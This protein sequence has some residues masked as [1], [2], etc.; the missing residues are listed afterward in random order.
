LIHQRIIDILSWK[1]NRVDILIKAMKFIRLLIIQL[2]V[3]GLAV[4]FTK[5]CLAQTKAPSAK[6]K[7]DTVYLKSIKSSN[8]KI[9]LPKIEDVSIYEDLFNTYGKLKTIQ[10]KGKK[11]RFLGDIKNISRAKYVNGAL[12]RAG[13]ANTRIT[14]FKTWVPPVIS[15]KEKEEKPK[16]KKEKEVA[17]QTAIVGEQVNK[18]KTSDPF[19]ARPKANSKPSPEKN[20]IKAEDKDTKPKNVDKAVDKGTKPTKPKSPGKVEDKGTKPAKPK[21]TNKVADKDTKPTKPKSPGKVEA[22]DTKPAKPKSVDK[23]AANNQGQ[24]VL[25]LP[26]VTNPE[27][28]QYVLKDLGT[29]D[30]KKLPNEQWYYFLGFFDNEAKAKTFIPK[31]KERGFAKP[32]KIAN[33]KNAEKVALTM[34]KNLPPITKKKSEPKKKNTSSKNVD[35]TLFYRIEL[36]RVSNPEIYFKAFGDIGPGHSEIAPNG[37]GIYYIGEFETASAATTKMAK[38]KERGLNN[39]TVVKFENDKRLDPYS[40]I[41]LTIPKEEKNENVKKVEVKKRVSTNPKGSFQIRMKLVENPDV[42]KAVFKDVGKLKIGYYD[43]DSEYYYM[44]NYLFQEEAK[45]VIGQLKERGLTQFKL[46][47]VMASGNTPAIPKTKSRNVY[48]IK[49]GTLTNAEQSLIRPYG[50]VTNTKIENEEVYYLGDYPTKKV[51]NII[52]NVLKEVGFKKSMN[53]EFFSE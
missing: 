33:L 12:N 17:S 16:E 37:K 39:G 3:I 26:K 21:S 43:D 46:L 53:V 5:D 27:V 51:A 7:I 52:A 47:N 32:P 22:K 8:F 38:L 4:S 11:R 23:V 41:Y 2:I 13:I 24:F 49:L 9:R 34:Y 42:L 28:Y 44:G 50:T 30:H 35:K 31:I 14:L 6:V 40:E 1:L 18:K 19:P 45:K 29:V 10:V 36:P 20:Y 15:K 48:K 25:I